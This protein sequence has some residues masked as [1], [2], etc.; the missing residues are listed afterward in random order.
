[1]RACPI[2][3]TRTRIA[4]L[5]PYHHA[6]AAELAVLVDLHRR[7]RRRDEREVENL[8]ELVV[9]GHHAVLLRNHA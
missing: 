7:R 8:R 4:D 5:A 9:L 3:S 1:M 6:L 2:I